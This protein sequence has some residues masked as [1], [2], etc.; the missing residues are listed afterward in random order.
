MIISRWI[1]DRPVRLIRGV[2]MHFCGWET[3]THRGCNVLDKGNVLVRGS[4]EEVIAPGS[5]DAE[6]QSTEHHRIQ[7]EVRGCGAD[8]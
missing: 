8:V 7:W 2:R 6:Q 5:Q 1:S 4:E 3:N